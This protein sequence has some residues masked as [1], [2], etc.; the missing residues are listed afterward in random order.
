MSC[1]Y[2]CDLPAVLP[3]ELSRIEPNVITVDNHSDTQNLSL[4]LLNGREA[5]VHTEHTQ[6]DFALR[7]DDA[8]KRCEM[9]TDPLRV[10]QQKVPSSRH[11]PRG[12][13]RLRRVAAQRECEH[14]RAQPKERERQ[15]GCG[16]S[17]RWRH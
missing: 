1:S 13:P 10:H 2:A 3:S 7:R 9:L 16:G 17:R 5:G 11:Q 15:L 12:D 8:L 4:G 14:Q 6:W